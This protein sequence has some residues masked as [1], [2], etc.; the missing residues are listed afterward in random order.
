M[1]TINIE[2]V[3]LEETLMAT[4]IAITLDAAKGDYPGAEKDRPTIKFQVRDFKIEV[5]CYPDHNGPRDGTGAAT[6]L[7]NSWRFEVSSP[8]FRVPDAIG[9]F[10]EEYDEAKAEAQRNRQAC[11]QELLTS[12]NGMAELQVVEAF[13]PRVC[14]RF[15]S[16]VRE[17]VKA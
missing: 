3:P 6:C 17:N 15:S 8:E 9:V 13:A 10:D 12:F 2:T 5:T 7:W 1:T 11:I 14:V 4:A 16:H